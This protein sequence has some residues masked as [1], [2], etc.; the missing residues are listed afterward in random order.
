[1]LYRAEKFTL[2]YEDEMKKQ[3]GKCGADDIR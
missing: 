2:K 3:K 1:M